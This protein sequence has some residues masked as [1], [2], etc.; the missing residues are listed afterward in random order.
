MK[1]F[2]EHRKEG[3]K[4]MGNLIKAE[5]NMG[6]GGALNQNPIFGQFFDTSPENCGMVS[7]KHGERF[8]QHILTMKKRY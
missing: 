1:G 6:Y 4:K 5:K 3:R 8:L 7:D 2:F